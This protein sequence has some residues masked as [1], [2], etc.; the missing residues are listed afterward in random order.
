[1]ES[2]PILDLFNEHG[3]FVNYIANNTKTSNANNKPAKIEI[4]ATNYEV[5]Q[6]LNM[7]N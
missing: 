7:F 2:K 6:Q 3:L 5:Q 1:M 4:M